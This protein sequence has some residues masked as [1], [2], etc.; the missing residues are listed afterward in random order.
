MTVKQKATK[1]LAH[2]A[3]AVTLVMGA[4]ATTGSAEAF[5]GKAAKEL[6]E[7]LAKTTKGTVKKMPRVNRDAEQDRV[8][9]KLFAAHLGIKITCKLEYLWCRKEVRE[10]V[11]RKRAERKG[12]RK[13]H[14]SV[15]CKKWGTPNLTARMCGRREKAPY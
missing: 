15:K 14:K 8:Q 9:L 12:T 10:R 4:A 7:I 2:F 3:L 13:K 1:W 5:V 6:I 11:E